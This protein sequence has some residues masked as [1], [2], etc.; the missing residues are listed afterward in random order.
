[1]G[2][3]IVP[4]HGLQNFGVISLL[5]SNVRN[6]GATIGFDGDYNGSLN[7]LGAILRS[8]LNITY[9]TNEEMQYVDDN[10]HTLEAFLGKSLPFSEKGSIL[11]VRACLE[12]VHLGIQ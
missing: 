3:A 11:P 9:C 10:R 7:R 4:H 12:K 6:V 8:S 1:V 2:G 5:F